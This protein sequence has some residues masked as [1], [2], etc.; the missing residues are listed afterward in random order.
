MRSLCNIALFIVQNKE[1]T[2]LRRQ[3]DAC[4]G[5]E[6]RFYVHSVYLLEGI[7]AKSERRM[8]LAHDP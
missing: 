6:E 3:A 4:Q 5:Q 8:S 2:V 1:E 7:S